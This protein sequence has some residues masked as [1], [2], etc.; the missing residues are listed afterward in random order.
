M[1]EPATK[2]LNALLKK[3]T[4][5]YTANGLIATAPTPFEDSNQVACTAQGLVKKLNLANLNTL[6]RH[7][8]SIVYAANQEHLLRPDGLV[9]L[10]RDYG[11]LFRGLEIKPINERYDAIRSGAAQCVYAF[12]TDPEIQRLKLKVLRDPKGSFSGTPSHGFVALRKATADANP[13]PAGRDRSRLERADDV[14]HPGAEVGG[15]HPPAL[16]AQGGGG[17]PGRA[18]HPHAGAGERGGHRAPGTAVRRPVGGAPPVGKSARP[19]R[20]FFIRGEGRVTARRQPA[21]GLSAEGGV[22]TTIRRLLAGPTVGER[23]EAR[24]AH[25]D[26]QGHDAARPERAGRD[27]D[28][29]AVGAV[30]PGGGRDRDRRADRPGGADRRPVHLRHLR[31]DRRRPRRAASWT[32]TTGN[33]PGTVVTPTNPG[34]IVSSAGI[35]AV[36]RKRSRSSTCRRAP[37]PART[38]TARSRP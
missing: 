20:V 4:A 18:R 33:Q 16:V 32:Q 35:T 3:V 25:H 26:P 38:T 36:Q 29:H 23:T 14:A 10:A 15:R 17:V 30:P 31:P 11:A 2:D 6:R 5:R 12:S 24:P 34:L 22:K 28:D 9:V 13:G 8:R 37:P 21:G 1:N 7:P 19:T 27:R